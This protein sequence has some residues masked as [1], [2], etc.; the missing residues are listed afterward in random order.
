MGKIKP[1]LTTIKQSIFYTNRG[2]VT[3]YYI[4]KEF[5]EA[6]GYKFKKT[7]KVEIVNLMDNFT[8][9]KYDNIGGRRV[10]VIRIVQ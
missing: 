2:S 3:I 10:Y 1:I 9:A 4:A 5:L 6:I 7:D 8:N